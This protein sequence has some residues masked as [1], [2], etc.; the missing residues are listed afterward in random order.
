MSEH[1]ETKPKPYK[2]LKP[3]TMEEFGTFAKKLAKN[4]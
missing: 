2:K 1:T 3:E 4:V